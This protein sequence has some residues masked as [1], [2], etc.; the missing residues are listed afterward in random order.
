M[1]RLLPLL[2]FLL[3]CTHS[4]A[5]HLTYSE[6]MQVAKTERWTIINDLLS[7]KGFKF[8]GN[9]EKSDGPIAYWTKNFSYHIDDK[10]EMVIDGFVDVD[11]FEWIIIRDTKSKNVSM[12][13]YY[14]Y[15][16]TAYDKFIQAAQ[17]DGFE[18]VHDAVVDNGIS[19]VYLNS[20]SS[21]NERSDILTIRLSNTGIYQI[22]F[23]KLTDE[24]YTLFIE[25]LKLQN[26][27]AR[28]K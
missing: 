8:A 1:K 24:Q 5:Q 26:D 23:L 10:G 16:K 7:S 19:S 6:F 21:E 11:N 3:L 15:L 20:P 2:L 25:A 9:V 22:D 4:F 28:N 13:S 12:T 18:L 17:K 27:K 14:F